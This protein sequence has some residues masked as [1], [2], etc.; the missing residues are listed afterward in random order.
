M[1]VEL[2]VAVLFSGNGSV[3]SAGVTVAVLTS[4]LPVWSRPT[5]ATTVR[6]ALEPPGTLPVQGTFA[7]EGAHD[8]PTGAPTETNVIPA[9]RVSV[10]VGEGASDGPLLVAVIV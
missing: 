4:V 8:H 5:L 9:G 2:A 3:A 1:T 6:T 7:P 10:T